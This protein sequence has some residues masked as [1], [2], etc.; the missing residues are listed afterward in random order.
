VIEDF[1]DI[2]GLVATCILE[3]NLPIDLRLHFAA[4]LIYYYYY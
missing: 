4:D 2:V 1:S 3:K